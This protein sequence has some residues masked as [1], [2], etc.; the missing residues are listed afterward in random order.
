MARLG[1][2]SLLSP[3]TLTANRTPTLET[4]GISYENFHRIDRRAAAFAVAATTFGIGSA[5]ADPN[6]Y[7]VLLV[8]PN[9]V[10]DS[11]AY[12]AGA[13]VLNPNNQPGVEVVYTHRDGSRQITE[14]VW[15]LGDPASATA[16]MNAAQSDAAGQIANETTQAVQVGTG[17]TMLSGTSADGSKA[18]SVVLFTQGNT[19]SAIKFT[20]PV[21][22]P[23]SPEMATAT[24]LARA[25]LRFTA[26]LIASPTAF[27]STIAFSLIALWGVASAAYASTRYC[28]PACDSS[29]SLIDEVVMSSPIRG[30]YFAPKEN[31]HCGRDSFINPFSFIALGSLA[32]DP[33]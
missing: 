2:L 29:I 31:A 30:R 23:A 33:L 17:G 28:P 14:T 13:P 4:G 32:A 19:A 18:V 12:S 27:A 26:R 7:T 3:K 20:G 16:A 24:S 5:A 25:P 11:T 10:W 21:A 9:E 8:N 15:V 22:D 1:L 6:D